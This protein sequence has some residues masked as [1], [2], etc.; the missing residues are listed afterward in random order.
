MNK[1]KIKELEEDYA[2]WRDVQKYQIE[3]AD[4]KWKKFKKRCYY[5]VVSPWKYICINVRDWRTWIIFMSVFLLLSSEVWVFYLL[6]IITGNEWFYGVASACWLFWLGPFTPFL[7]LVISLT[8]GIR[9]VF[10]KWKNKKKS[11]KHQK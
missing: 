10:K 8:I 5:I 6:G 4:T 11:K 1:D 7:P 9:E 3:I 2:K